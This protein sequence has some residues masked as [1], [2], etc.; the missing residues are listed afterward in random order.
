MGIG[1][2]KSDELRN[3]NSRL[4]QELAAA[5]IEDA[6]ASTANN[7]LT[8][9]IV[10]ARADLAAALA[11]NAALKD[12]KGSVDAELSQLQLEHDDGDVDDDPDGQ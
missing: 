7:E 9:D 10:A 1:H 4:V 8:S 12:A 6:A 11:A 2:S 3:E 5:R